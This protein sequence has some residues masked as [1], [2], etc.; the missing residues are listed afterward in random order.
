M[1]T[2]IITNSYKYIKMLIYSENEI[3]RISKISKKTRPIINLDF[4][5]IIN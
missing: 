4:P 3:L 5:I 2:K 1:V